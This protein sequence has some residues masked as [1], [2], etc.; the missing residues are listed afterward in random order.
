MSELLPCPHCGCEA[1]I[2]YSEDDCALVVCAE[3]SASSALYETEAEAI[4][5][6]N[7]RVELPR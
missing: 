4:A 1:D 6:W 2:S 5:A 3:C 7:H